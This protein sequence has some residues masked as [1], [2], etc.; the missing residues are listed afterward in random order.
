MHDITIYMHF[1]WLLIFDLW[2]LNF[3]NDHVYLGFSMPIQ[4][5]NGILSRWRKFDFLCRK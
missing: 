2:N 5:A 4:V 3:L 1:I